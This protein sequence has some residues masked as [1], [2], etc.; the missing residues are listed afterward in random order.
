MSRPINIGVYL[1]LIL[2][3]L[4]ILVFNAQIT[5]QDNSLVYGSRLIKG[6]RNAIYLLDNNDVKHHFPDF[7]TFQSLGFNVTTVQ[8]MKDRELNEMKL[9]NYLQIY[10]NLSTTG[11]IY[12]YL[13]MN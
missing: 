9:G 10:I 13:H 6:S 11:Y 8:S 2:L 4:N 5:L 1:H 12:A 3:Y 7:Y